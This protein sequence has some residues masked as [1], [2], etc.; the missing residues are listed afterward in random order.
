MKTFRNQIRRALKDSIL[1]EALQAYAQQRQLG[2][3]KAFASLLQSDQVREMARTIRLAAI[4]NLEPLLERFTTQLKAIGVQVHYAKDAQ[5][6]QAIIQRIASAHRASL[7]VKSKSMLSEEIRMNQALESEG[8]KVVETDLGEYIVQLRGENPS[9]IIT[10]AMHLKREQVA[11][12][13]VER[14]AIPYSTNVPDLTHAAHQ[15]LREMFINAEIGVS[16]VNFGIAE[17]GTLCIVTNEGN[18]RMVT[19]LPRVH[20]ALM[21]IERLLPKLVD[22]SPMLQLLPRSATGQKLTSYVSLLHGP[23]QGGDLDGSEERHIILID[24]G[25]RALRQSN[26]QEALLCIRCGACLNVCP[27]FQGIGGHAYASPYPGPIGAVISPGFWGMEAYGHLAKASTLCGMCQEVCP[28]DINLPSMLLEVRQESQAQISRNLTQSFF[29]RVYTWIMT[30]PRRYSWATNLA[31]AV[32]H[33]LPQKSGWI[34]WAPPPFSA[35]TKT[36]DLPRFNKPNKSLGEFSAKLLSAEPASHTDEAQKGHPEKAKPNHLNRIDLWLRHN[37]EVD[38]EVVICDESNLVT[39]LIE[40]VFKMQT[41]EILLSPEVAQVYPEL[42]SA[43]NREQ[44]HLINPYVPLKAEAE[45]RTALLRSFDKVS[46]GIT[47]ANAGLAE[48]GSI[49]LTQ[50]NVPSNLAS[51]L[52][53]THLAILR[54]EDIYNDMAHWLGTSPPKNTEGTTVILSGP[55]R[56]ADIEMTL[57]IGV[58]GPGRLMVFLVV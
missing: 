16:G 11:E 46:L 7:I 37:E 18:G 51:L 40:F 17:S 28:V 10:P 33:I 45:V 5:E 1:Q 15:S 8:L 4:Q 25:R 44:I 54:A 42:S 34:R 22:L 32:S 3:E 13:F 24:N 50:A 9:H 30:S 55:S 26:L 31:A 58:H 20:I 48:T 49:I 39:R 47:T 57:T 27:V 19:T 41:D 52:P 6:A 38:S 14:L 36:R 12:T 56:T 35:W 23:R 43:L 2:R 29:L 53:H 21:G